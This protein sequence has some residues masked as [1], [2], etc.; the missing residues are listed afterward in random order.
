MWFDDRVIQPLLLRRHMF[1][2]GRTHGD[3][4]I[5]EGE[6]IF[7]N[8]DG[9]LDGL[10]IGY[11]FDGRLLEVYRIDPANLAADVLLFRG[12]MGDPTLDT[13][14]MSVPVYDLSC[15]FDRSLQPT[16]FQGNNSLPN[17]LEGT[18]DDLLGQPKPK[19][20]G[21]VFNVEPPLVNTSR[22]IYQINDTSLLPGYTLAA[23]DKRVA[24]AAG[25]LRP[26][27]DFTSGASSA[28][29]SSIDTALDQ[30]TTGAPHGFTTADPVHVD[31]TAA[32]PGGVLNTQYY[33]ARVIS[34]TVISLHPTAADASANTAK[35]DITSAGSGTITVAKNRTPYGC[36]DWCSDSS[37]S[38]VRTGLKA[39]RL[40]CDIV[41]G[42]L[43]TFDDVLNQLLGVAKSTYSDINAIPFI[44]FDRPWNQFYRVG[45]WWNQDMTIYQ[46]FQELMR[47]M[48][49]NM[50]VYVDSN[51]KNLYLYVQ[52]PL[53]GYE[54]FSPAT[55]LELDDSTISKGTLQRITPQDDERGVPPW[56]VAVGY[57]HN[58]TLMSGADVAGAAAADVASVAQEY[59]T[60]FNDLSP[61]LSYYP[62][63][64]ELTVNTGLEDQSDA[65]SLA[66]YYNSYL[67][68][69]N[70]QMFTISV[71]LDDFMD[72]VAFAP[73]ILG[74]I[75]G[76]LGVT[77]TYPRFGMDS[78]HRFT[79]VSYVMDIAAKKVDLT[80]WG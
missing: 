17:G 64:P 72:N 19:V 57:R 13:E 2:E 10:S 31:S 11:G 42:S 52:T 23:Y 4:Q 9:E 45:F 59:L 47:C 49:A 14:Q 35:I 50:Q 62:S 18:S 29:V 33:Y 60:S 63:S 48:N 44:L 39:T 15:I 30:I 65:S 61:T 5:P 58:Y 70:M 46:A 76:Q 56:R 53:A 1:G 68:A 26:I 40:T 16:K 8:S 66:V 80:L 41:N 75:L 78:G 21:S 28:T 7:G 77:V 24:L 54:P 27:G 55:S 6:V 71:G 12:I 36:Y 22:L 25:I 20:M 34:I 74:V 69:P 38:Y 51:S 43:V 32:L 3:S 67:L 79:P 73:G 37:G